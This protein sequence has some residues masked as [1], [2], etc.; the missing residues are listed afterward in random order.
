MFRSA[1]ARF[2]PS[3]P[4]FIIIVHHPPSIIWLVHISTS[5]SSV[6]SCPCLNTTTGHNGDDHFYY[7]DVSDRSQ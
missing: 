5:A 7:G 6:S 1:V 4:Y 2:F 3:V